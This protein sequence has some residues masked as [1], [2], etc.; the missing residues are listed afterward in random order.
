MQTQ[1][2]YVPREEEGGI[3]EYEPAVISG[4]T[5]REMG[6]ERGPQRNALLISESYSC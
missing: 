6:R 5:E 2:E 1:V 4:E 3:L